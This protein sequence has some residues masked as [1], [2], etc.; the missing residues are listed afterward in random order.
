MQMAL[1]LQVAVAGLCFSMII[2]CPD[3]CRCDERR[4]IVYCNE[5]QL[6]RI[7]F[8]I[9]YDTKFLLLQGNLLT[10]SPTLESILGT[11]TQLEKL[12][13][14]D[15][16]LLSFPNNLPPSLTYLSLRLNGIKFIGKSV[17]SRLTNLEKLYLDSNNLTNTGVASSAF[18]SA[19][20]LKDL[21]LSNNQLTALPENLPPSLENLRIDFNSISI[22][23]PTSLQNLNNLLIFDLSQALALIS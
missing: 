17:L 18:S 6:T 16:R 19:T 8:G 4:K 5:R 7:P 11:L 2:C 15:N 3:E 13:L 9:P 12:D 20:A 14:H 1:L 21:V 23:T 10:N 22:V